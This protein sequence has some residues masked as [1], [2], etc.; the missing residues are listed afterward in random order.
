MF[1]RPELSEG[2]HT[3]RTLGHAVQDDSCSKL[4]LPTEEIVQPGLQ[5]AWERLSA[6]PLHP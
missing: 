2:L 4:H 6:D 1:Q 5:K 3:I